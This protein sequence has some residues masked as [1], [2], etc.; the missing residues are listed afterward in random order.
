METNC[1]HLNQS[2]TKNAKESSEEQV[3]TFMNLSMNRARARARAIAYV[4]KIWAVFD[5]LYSL[6]M[7][8]TEIS[9]RE[10]KGKGKEESVSF[11]DKQKLLEFSLFNTAECYTRIYYATMR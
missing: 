6:V 11:Q 9:A 3:L 1:R 2:R 8:T 4:V 10:K 7:I 5:R